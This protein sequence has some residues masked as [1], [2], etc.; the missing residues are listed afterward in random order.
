M[1]LFDH[2][3]NGFMSILCKDSLMRD[4]H[5]SLGKNHLC[6]ISN[7]K[8]MHVWLPVHMHLCGC[9]ASCG[10]VAVEGKESFFGT[11]A[12]TLN[13]IK[14]SNRSRRQS[15]PMVAPMW[16]KGLRSGALTSLEMTH[17]SVSLQCLVN[18]QPWVVH[19]LWCHYKLISATIALPLWHLRPLVVKRRKTTWA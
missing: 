2:Q 12:L 9:D 8:P 5:A 3:F 1:S 11:S 15:R 16:L 19:N 17:Y 7:V 13:M 10:N 4:C 6:R 14:Q 18:A